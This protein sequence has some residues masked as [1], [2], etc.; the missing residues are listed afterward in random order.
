MAIKAEFAGY[1]YFSIQAL[2]YALLGLTYRSYIQYGK[3]KGSF[4]LHGQYL[5]LAHG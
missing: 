4:R 1:A 5:P 3:N 2:Q